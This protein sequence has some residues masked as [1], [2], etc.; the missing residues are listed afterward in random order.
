[1]FSWGEELIFAVT[2]SELE[3]NKCMLMGFTRQG[4]TKKSV[5]VHLYTLTMS[6]SILASLNVNL[7]CSHIPLSDIICFCSLH[8]LVRDFTPSFVV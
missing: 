3:N 8:M 5:C 1:M 4:K 2:R 6:I 7:D